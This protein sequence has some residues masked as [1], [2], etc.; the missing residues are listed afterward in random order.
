MARI[1][2]NAEYM[3]FVHKSFA[4]CWFIDAG[5]VWET[6]SDVGVDLNIS[7]G[8]GI[9]LTTPGF[10]IRLDYGIPLHTTWDHLSG[11]TG[12]FHFSMSTSF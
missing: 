9:Q 8:M 10:P 12:R 6:A 3:Y 5:N 4:L 11:N 1:V 2:A 7:T